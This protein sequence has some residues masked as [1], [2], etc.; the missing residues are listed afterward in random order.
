MEKRIV[1]GLLLAVLMTAASA[2]YDASMIRLSGYRHRGNSHTYKDITD[3]Q[4]CNATFH[5]WNNLFNSFGGF[6]Y[7]ERTGECKFVF[8][9]EKKFKG[10]MGYIGGDKAGNLEQ[11]KEWTHFLHANVITSSGGSFKR[12]FDAL[13]HTDRRKLASF[14]PRLASK[15]K[16]PIRFNSFRDLMR[17]AII[18]VPTCTAGIQAYN[19]GTGQGVSTGVTANAPTLGAALRSCSIT[20]SCVGVSYDSSTDIGILHLTAVTSVSNVANFMYFDKTC[21]TGTVNLNVATTTTTTTTVA[22][23]VAPD[24]MSSLIGDSGLCPDPFARFENSSLA[25]GLLIQGLIPATTTEGICKARCF[26]N[27][28]CVAVDYNVDTRQCFEHTSLNGTFSSGT[29]VGVTHFRKIDC[30]PTRCFQQTVS[31]S[32]IPATVDMQNIL[33]PT[34]LTG[35]VEAECLTG[36]CF[37]EYTFDQTNILAL[38]ESISRGCSG[39]DSLP[40]QGCSTTIST[41]MQSYRCVCLGD[42]CNSYDVFTQD[43]LI[44]YYPLDNTGSDLSGYFRDATVNSV[45]FDQADAKRNWSAVFDGSTSYFQ[46]NTY[47][48]IQIG[49]VDVLNT[50]VAGQQATAGFAMT[51][52]IKRT[53]TSGDETIL[54]NGNFGSAPIEI[55]SSTDG[56]NH[57]ITATFR[58]RNEASNTSV[59]VSGSIAALN[60]NAWY[61]VAIEMN[62]NAGTSPTLNMNLYAGQTLITEI[63]TSTTGSSVPTIMT[64]I[65]VTFAP[66]CIGKQFGSGTI[67]RFFTGRLDDIRVFNRGNMLAAAYQSIMDQSK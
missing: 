61:F 46:I 49:S 34:T 54:S 14:S 30:S 20:A 56:V 28:T 48:S 8:K 9:S 45:T 4:N 2:Q 16:G 10:C 33:S 62:T 43:E 29:I 42:R 25:G 21:F 55:V 19:V 58:V 47:T 18:S 36:L 50:T 39:V 11:N 6:N 63:T 13:P 3:V 38:T 27:S 59:N 31:N 24:S 51:M 44:G 57:T 12:C 26:Q 15:F 60:L 35:I 23:S 65:R 17:Q 5:K 37:T 32:A 22:P 41:T 52:W 7:N 67:G 1:L 53:S 40:M 66:L 64:P